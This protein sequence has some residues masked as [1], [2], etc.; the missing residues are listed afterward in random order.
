M[1]HKPSSRL[2]MLFR[3]WWKEV[4]ASSFKNKTHTCISDSVEVLSGAGELI[5]EPTLVTALELDDNKLDTCKYR[6]K[7]KGLFME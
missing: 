6:N 3:L 7:I 5:S 4:H 2:E 1:K